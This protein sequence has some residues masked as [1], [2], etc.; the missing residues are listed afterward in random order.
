[1]RED[2]KV[3]MMVAVSSALEYMKKNPNVDSEEIIKYVMKSVK[4]KKNAK[5]GAIAAANKAIIQRQK[6]PDFTDKKIMQNIM[7]EIDDISLGLE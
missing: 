2:D 1:M 5:I 6:N 3:S 4:S 7:N